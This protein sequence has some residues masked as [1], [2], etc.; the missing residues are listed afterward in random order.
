VLEPTGHDRPGL[1]VAA[2]R[3]SMRRR[4]ASSRGSRTGAR[5]R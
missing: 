5:P 1:H 4:S 3:P 2:G